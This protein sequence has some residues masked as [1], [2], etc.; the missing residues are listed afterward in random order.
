MKYLKSSAAARWNGPW[1]IRQ[2]KYNI[3]I[4]FQI[5]TI[6]PV[7]KSLAELKR[8]HAQMGLITIICALTCIGQQDLVW[9]RRVIISENGVTEITRQMHTTGLY[10]LMDVF[11]RNET[12]YWKMNM[13]YAN[14]YLLILLR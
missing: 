5:R 3:G 1:S 11:V 7:S 10:L 12:V 4:T 6:L 13:E 9:Y 2:F 14:V 8:K